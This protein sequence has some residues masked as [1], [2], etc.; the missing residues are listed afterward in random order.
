[1]RKL[2]RGGLVAVGLLVFSAG[3]ASASQAPAS[4]PQV[5]PASGDLVSNSVDFANAVVN[6]LP[7]HVGKFALKSTFVATSQL[8][9]TQVYG[10]TAAYTVEGGAQVQVIFFLPTNVGDALTRYNA[11]HQRLVVT[12][13]PLDLGDEAYVAPGNHG[14]DQPTDAIASVRYR[15][16]VI[17]I[18]PDNIANETYLTADA[19]VAPLVTRDDLTQFLE[20]IFH[21]IPF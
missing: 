6:A 7:K 8:S 14:G 20:A 5:S 15:N 9:N 13:Y 11:M 1:M 17:E 18:D 10:L 19:E 4:T 16:L 2:W 12:P 3:C 21:A